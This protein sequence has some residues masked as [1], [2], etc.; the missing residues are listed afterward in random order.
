MAATLEE[1]QDEEEGLKVEVDSVA[2]EEDPASTRMQEVWGW[3]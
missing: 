1:V 2:E 3:G